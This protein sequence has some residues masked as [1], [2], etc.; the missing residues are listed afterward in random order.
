MKHL[1]LVVAALAL[2]VGAWLWHAP[3][4]LR[5]ALQGAAIT[6][7]ATLTGGG[8]APAGPGAA[9]TQS[10]RKCVLGSQVLYTDGACPG[11]SRPQTVDSD[12]L[13][14]LPAAPK[15]AA[16]AAGDA[17]G[18]A[19]APA[20]SAALPHVRGLLGTPQDGNLREKMMDRAINQ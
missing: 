4:G 6:L 1:L 20:S 11:G 8:T 9:A 12:R 16:V 15:P 19:A 14:V 10:L 5:S 17:A 7:P 2:L 3:S 18:P 13:S